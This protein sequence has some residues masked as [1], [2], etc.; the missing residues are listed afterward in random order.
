MSGGDRNRD[1][2]LMLWAY[3]DLLKKHFA[4]YVRV[5]TVMGRIQKVDRQR[6]IVEESGRA[7]D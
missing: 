6:R 2:R 3:E 1:T 5:L 7:T 4:E